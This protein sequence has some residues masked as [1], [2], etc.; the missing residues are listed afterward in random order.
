MTFL[1]NLIIYGLLGIVWIAQKI[2]GMEK[3]S[4]RNYQYTK[5]TRVN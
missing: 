1:I 4:K 2:S 5:I 3:E